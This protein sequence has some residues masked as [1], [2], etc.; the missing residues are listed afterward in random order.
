MEELAS[1]LSEA[2]KQKV[3]T[4]PKN[5]EELHKELI[6]LHEDIYSS[7]SKN[8]LTKAKCLEY[9]EQIFSLQFQLSLSYISS[10][11]SHGN[12]I[13]SL[14]EDV[15]DDW[16]ISLLGEWKEGS[17][18]GCLNENSWR[19]NEQYLLQIETPGTVEIH[20]EQIE[21][22]IQPIGFYIFKGFKFQQI[23]G[24]PTVVSKSAFKKSKI[25]TCS[26]EL[27]PSSDGYVSVIVHLPDE[28][29]QFFNN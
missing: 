27:Y 15:K 24:N 11:E 7:Y 21:E 8:Q 13:I 2:L 5:I 10:I 22:E 1:L 25:V 26:V 9:S 17:S 19:D 4:T 28:N 18:G 29:Y 23:V 6:S 3:Q 12:E 14:Q 20:L 16:H